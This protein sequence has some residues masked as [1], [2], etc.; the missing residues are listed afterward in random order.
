MNFKPYEKY[1][2]CVFPT[3]SLSTKLVYLQLKETFIYGTRWRSWLSTVVQAGG[4]GGRGFD[5]L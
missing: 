5:F 4:G 2:A 3:H 1:V